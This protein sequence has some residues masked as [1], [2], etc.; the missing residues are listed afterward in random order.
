MSIFIFPSA[1]MKCQISFCGAALLEETL[2]KDKRV[3]RR[4]PHV[5]PKAPPTLHSNTAAP[6]LLLLAL[7]I[8]VLIIIGKE[9]QTQH[10]IF[11][12]YKAGLGSLLYNKSMILV[13]KETFSQ[14]TC[15]V[16]RP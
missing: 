4:L 3:W 13:A 1:I 12:C 14:Q 5:W 11:R 9:K 16:E 2:L 10:R 6:V 15:K 7:A 8:C